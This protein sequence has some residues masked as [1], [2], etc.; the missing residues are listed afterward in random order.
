M[1]YKKQSQTGSMIASH[2]EW[3]DLPIPDLF[4]AA[5]TQCSS[6]NRLL[7]SSSV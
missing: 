6:Y 2:F 7:K 4:C 5:D 3:R 1:G